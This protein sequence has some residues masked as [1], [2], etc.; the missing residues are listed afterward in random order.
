MN[1]RRIIAGNWKLNGTLKEA[2]ELTQ[3]VLKA[4]SSL[5]EE[6]EVVLCPPFTALSKVGE[7]LKGSRI[8]LGA[9]DVH[10]EPKGAFTG[11]V[12][13]PLLKEAGC[14]FCII[15]HSERR[16]WFGETD[17]NVHKKLLALIEEGLHPIL[18]VGETLEQRQR[19]H[20]WE[21]IRRQLEAALEGLEPLAAARHLVIAYEPVW[22]IGTGQ[23][24]TP[25]QAQEVHAK[26][27]GWLSTRFGKAQAQSIRIQYGGS[28]KPENAKELL[29][30]TDVDGALVGGSS[31][32]VKSFV[33][34]VESSP[35][36]R[37]AP[38]CTG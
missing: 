16:L 35:Q 36:G 5:S 9:Q 2:L 13:A 18:C 15:G 3:G 37:Q 21:I 34:I 4:L 8:R 31:L 10:W 25:A 32:Q 1:R 17:S 24:A 23:N 28:V 6:V 26:I 14:R 19:G 7:L 30:Q 12:S 33:Q 11:E 38:C 27:R 22:A 20:T 29:A